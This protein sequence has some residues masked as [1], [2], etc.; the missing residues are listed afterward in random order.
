MCPESER[1]P[2]SRVP[3]QQDPQST[4][5]PTASS[6]ARNSARCSVRIRPI[7]LIVVRRHE[8]VSILSVTR[9]VGATRGPLQNPWNNLPSDREIYPGLGDCPDPCEKSDDLLQQLIPFG[10]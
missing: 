3:P 7:S 4:S 8:V 5:G 2:N 1:P 10:C 9:F 6:C